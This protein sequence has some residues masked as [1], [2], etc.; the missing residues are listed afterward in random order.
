[1]QNF[2]LFEDASGQ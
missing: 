2:H 1:V